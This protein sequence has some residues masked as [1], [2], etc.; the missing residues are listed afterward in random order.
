MAPGEARPEDINQASTKADSCP[1]LS[2]IEGIRP[3]IS[4]SRRRH[5][6][7]FRRA[8]GPI[9]ERLVVG[10]DITLGLD[11]EPQR[12]GHD[13]HPCRGRATTTLPEMPPAG[14]RL[15]RPR[16]WPR[17]A[18]RAAADGPSR[19]TLDFANQEIASATA[20][21]QLAYYEMLERRGLLRMIRTA[22]DSTPIWKEWADDPAPRRSATSWPWKGPTR[23]STSPCRGLVG[24]GAALG[25]S[26][27]LRQEPLRRRHRRRGPADA[28]RDPTSRR[29]S[30]GSA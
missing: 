10:R 20:R 17:Q 26:G 3:L 22:A 4:R 13:D 12:T 28:G 19:M 29:S 25:E 8:S 14:S 23:S 6:D 24:A 11:A 15:A 9:V 1:I 5:E 30:N 21:G 27:P 16:C 18:R 2:R 7:S